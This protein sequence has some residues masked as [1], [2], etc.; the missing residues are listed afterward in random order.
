MM[1]SGVLA[2]LRYAFGKTRA[3]AQNRRYWKNYLARR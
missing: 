2:F 3:R 1:R